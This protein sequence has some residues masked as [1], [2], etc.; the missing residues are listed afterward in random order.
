MNCKLFRT[1]F[2]KRL[3]MLVAVSEYANSQ[4]KAQGGHRSPLPNPIAAQFIGVLTLCVGLSSVG[5]AQTV[6]HNALPT[7]A[8][9]SAGL[10]IVSSAGAN[11]TIDQASQRASIN[12]QSFNIGKDASV[13][14]V[15]PN[16][17]SVLLNRIG[18]D[19]PSQ[20]LGRLSANGQ[21]VLVN[22]NGMMFGKDG[23]VSAAA[24]TA[25]SLGIS[26]ADFMA[27]NMTFSRQDASGAIVNQGRLEAH[28]GVIALLGAQVSNEG[29]I[30]SNAGNVY[31]GAAETVQMPISGSGRI[32]LELS[33]SAIH[34]VVSNAG[35][36][37]TMGGHV[38]MQASAAS[39]AI[40][41]VIHSG[42]IDTSAATAGNV[43]LLADHGQIKVD[44]IITSNSTGKDVDGKKRAGANI[45]IGRDE[46]SEKLA[47]STDVRGARL[48]SVGGFVETSGEL[49]KFDNVSVV[50]KD[51]LLDPVDVNID[52][53]NAATIGTNLGTTNVTVQTTGS[54]LG[55]TSAGTGNITVS[56]A[57]TKAA[58]AGADTTLTLIADNGITIN[59][60]IGAATGAGKLDVVMTAN[61]LTDG[62]S[63]DSMTAA[64]RALSRGLFINNTSIHANGGNITLTGTSYADASTSNNTNA[65]ATNAIGKGVQIHFGS[66]LIGNNIDVIGVSETLG[67][68]TGTGVLI[69]RFPTQATI[70]ANGNIAITGTVQGAGKGT[71]LS[72]AESGWGAQ[73]PKM[74]AGG[75][76]TLRGNNRADASNTQEAVLIK[77]GLQAM[78]GGNIVLQ[79]E[80]NNAAVNAIKVDSANRSP[81]S[82]ALQGNMTLQATGNVLIQS[83]QGGIALNNQLPS[84]LANG[85]LTSENKITGLN[86]T[87][88]NTGAGM[89]TGANHTLG[90]GSID[91]VTG[92][93][94]R[95]A[96]KSTSGI[97][98]VSIADGRPITAANNINIFGAGTAGNG[99]SISGAASLTAN[100]TGY[101]GN[102]NIAGENTNATAGNAAINISNAAS[103]ITAR[104]LVTFLSSGL[105]SGVSLVAA[106]NITTSG[107]LQIENPASG[108]ISGIVSGAGMLRKRGGTG[109]GVLSLT[110]TNTYTGGTTA[111]GGI[112]QVGNGG[113]TGTLGTGAISVGAVLAVKRSDT[114]EISE[115][116]SGV[117]QLMQIG[118]GRTILTG[119]NSYAGRTTISGG[120][121]QV[122]N[123]GNTGTLGRGDVILSN[124]SSLNFVRSSI[125]AIDNKI[126]GAGNVSASI[127][128]D[129]SSLSVNKD[130]DL[131]NGTINLAADSNLM[132]AAK[133]ATTSSSSSA[134]VLNAGKAKA[135]GDSSGGDI[136]ISGASNISV[137]D[138]GRATLMTGSVSGS[139]GLSGLIGEGS[140]RFRY[141]SNES[142]KNYTAALGTGLYAI[143]REAPVYTVT[144]NS[145][146]KTY[147]GQTYNGGN[148]YVVGGSLNGDTDAGTTGAMLYTGTA[149]GALNAGTYTI[150][151]SGL[152]SSLGYVQGEITDG[153]LTIAKAAL[154]A[155][156]NSLTTSYNG[157][158]QSVGG[159]TLTGLQGSDSVADLSS[160]QASGASGKNAGSYAN[161]VTAGSETNYT[162]TT[163]NG[164]LNIGK[165]NLTLAGTRTYDSGT[166]FAGQ[167]LTAT[168]VN[169]ESFAVTGA[170]DTSNLTS[171][172]VADNQGGALSS[173][174]GL[175]LGAS[176]NGGLSDNYNALSTSGSSVT[177]TKA[178]ATVTGTVTNVT[179]NG[180]T[181]NQSAATTSGFIAGDAITISGEAS[182]KNAGTYTSAL[183]VTGNDADNYN[184][185]VTDAD[186]SIAKANL[187]LTAGTDSKTYDA[188][189][190]SS[191]TVTVSGLQG[192]DTVTGLSQ[193]FDS[194]S[195]GNR[196]LG[197]NA[198]YTVN[199]GNSGGNYTVSTRNATGTIA[200][201]DV[202]LSAMTADNKTYDGND[203]AAITSGNVLGTVAG[204][205]LSV[206]GSGTFDTKNAGNG[207]TV[208]VNDVA[209][210]SKN[211]GSGDWANY[212][213][214]TMGALTTTATISPRT[215][216]ASLVG[217]V[218]K[219]YDSTTNATLSAGNFSLGGFVTGEGAS[220]SQTI[221]TYAS[222]NVDA[223]GGNGAVSAHLLPGQFSANAGTLLSNYMLPVSASGNVGTITPAALT[224]KVNNT[225]A[226]V[227]QDAN[228]ASNNG[229]SYSGLQGLD[230]E[231]TA[232]VRVPVANDRTYSGVT[233]PVAGTYSGVYGLG[234][235]P[236]AQHGNY[237]VT[238]ENGHLTVIPADH[239][240]IHVASQADTYGNRNTLN[241]GKAGSVTAQYC[242]AAG[243]C[244]GPNL[245]T[246]NMLSNDG[247]HWS[248]TD[249]TGTTVHFDT[250]VATAGNLSQGGVSQCRQPCM[251]NCK[252]D[253]QQPW[254]VQRHHG[255]QWN[256]GHQSAG[257]DPNSGRHQQGL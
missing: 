59:A 193:S 133:L 79:G 134:I 178:N 202:T 182:G 243:D 186:L 149:Q 145:F 140:G 211:N 52:A 190:T 124:D 107:E 101:T 53:A 7:G 112:L 26:D 103:S 126:T 155:T 80:T 114:F 226:F 253:E 205:T 109:A 39:A 62:V 147:D 166:T 31:M 87:I 228:A 23:S 97:A 57:I 172:H 45:V 86:I 150:S 250:S 223:N 176:S 194:K 162:V 51:W 234:Y 120:A 209:L 88:D 70:N 16:A 173:V 256:A 152:S 50:A 165:A 73:A 123:G 35:D 36:I 146:T 236:A 216:S 251:G 110:N 27:G 246:L 175:S 1:V 221:G 171:K 213:L 214:T 9:V 142:T 237:T 167:Y 215:L 184:V 244:N 69:Q 125:T 141:N 245:Y 170:G 225:T 203:S 231:A 257:A 224:I 230:S 96:G 130:I 32:K 19:S 238:V 117:G 14:V 61:G 139:T 90:S 247:T 54:T 222:A 66:T 74:T 192:S 93:I 119:T 255:G 75:N 22:P 28:G 40:A 248:A 235:T 219:T 60:P 34:A 174:T 41:N 82:N 78:A 3:G 187:T 12:W 240:L 220:V 254:P 128:G 217:S 252:S 127:T 77:S 68:A 208:T 20:I 108:T 46:E 102:I 21:I 81:W 200:R 106:G 44:G 122:G 206:S 137:G 241:A 8:T 85:S 153:T 168:G 118:T 183:H 42:S 204:E 198:G 164:T 161:T 181:Q 169:G 105:G 71:G 33:P 157:S 111:N 233:Y 121:L 98:G 144:L 76:I 104:N 196:R 56:S 154:T 100:T 185:T 143:Y 4:G 191:Q 218:S 49:L 138:G 131:T 116:I 229:Y 115:S 63:A 210:L 148:G 64:Q 11:M 212:Q 18:G 180:G 30:Y 151:G 113:T 179:Y 92:A 159:F 95:G 189:T 89:I 249:N 67:G 232:L 94:V 17:S 47:D 160:I 135:A 199:D 37:M 48:E 15:Q 29:K 25:S 83:N 5:W 197:V 129:S 84:D 43:H 136:V 6:A 2:S 227:T 72:L 207:K 38:F 13:N 91:A 239:L 99:V 177:L 158:T 132:V 55:V 58:A 163:V 10:A 201:K 188:T 242:L 24:L 65:S 156:G 195:A